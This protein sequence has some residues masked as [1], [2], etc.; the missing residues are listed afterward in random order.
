MLVFVHL[1]ETSF[2]LNNVG[3]SMHE[4]MNAIVSGEKDCQHDFVLFGST[5]RVAVP[6]K[7]LDLIKCVL[8]KPACTSTP[9]MTAFIPVQTYIPAK[10]CIDP[11]SKVHVVLCSCTPSEFMSRALFVRQLSVEWP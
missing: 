3:L 6:M 4:D 11:A 1:A 7:S 5:A 8:F 10:R 2:D 9:Y